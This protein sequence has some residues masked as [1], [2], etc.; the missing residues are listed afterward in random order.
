MV[1]LQR[2]RLKLRKM[3]VYSSDENDYRKRIRYFNCNVTIA[4]FTNVRPDVLG[5]GSITS[6]PVGRSTGDIGVVDKQIPNLWFIDLTWSF[7]PITSQLSSTGTGVVIV[8][9]YSIQ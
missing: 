1:F 8:V 2:M 7:R 4:V 3:N 6:P 9:G 5:T